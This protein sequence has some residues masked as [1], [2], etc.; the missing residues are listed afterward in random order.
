GRFKSASDIQRP[1]VL[2]P[3]NLV[4]YELI[5]FTVNTAFCVL[6]VKTANNIPIK[7]IFLVF[8]GQVYGNSSD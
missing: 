1:T 3:C 5:N 6:L 8:G 7:F 2:L 4:N